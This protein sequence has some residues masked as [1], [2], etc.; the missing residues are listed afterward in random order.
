[1]RARSAVHGYIMKSKCFWNICQLCICSLKKK[2]KTLRAGKNSM[3]LISFIYVF[4]L[5][6]YVCIYLEKPQTIFDLA[7][8]LVRSKFPDQ[9]LAGTGGKERRVLTA[10]REVPRK[11]KTF[12]FQHWYG[13]WR[14]CPIWPTPTHGPK[15]P[16]F[17]GPKRAPCSKRWKWG[18][19]EWVES[20]TEGPGVLPSCQP[21]R[22][23]SRKGSRDDA[24][25]P[26]FKSP[27]CPHRSLWVKWVQSMLPILQIKG[28]KDSVPLPKVIWCPCGQTP[29]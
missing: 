17:P 9:E 13:P 29:V 23:S 12:N 21:H 8:R 10:A 6:T 20:K 25:G 26:G 22:N 24:W 3:L 1:M 11:P 27:L 28:F 19:G 18:K 15:K 7:T 5:C 2:K 4:Y 14:Q 16:S